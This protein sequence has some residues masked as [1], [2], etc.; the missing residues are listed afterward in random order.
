[1]KNYDLEKDI[2]VMCI[3]AVSFPDG[4]MDAYKKLQSLITDSSDRRYFGYS[5]PNML[6]TI[7]YKACAEVKNDEEAQK[8]GLETFTIKA[9]KFASMYIVDHMQDPESIGNAFKELLKNP[10]LDPQGYCLE[11][12]KDFDD[13]DVQCMVPLI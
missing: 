11:M 12:Y 7:I 1:M 13:K 5:H 8:L 4:V 2:Q 9:G 6:R 3:T 10:D